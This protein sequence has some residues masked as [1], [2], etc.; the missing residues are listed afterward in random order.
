MFKRVLIALESI[1]AS[2]TALPIILKEL[3]NMREEQLRLMQKA[4]EE[5]QNTPQRIAEIAEL[6][7]KKILIAGGKRDA[8]T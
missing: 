2:L 4:R 6:F 3:Q 7:S 8:G 1:A 5:T